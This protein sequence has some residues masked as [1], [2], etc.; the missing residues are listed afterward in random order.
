[1]IAL[2]KRRV[3]NNMMKMSKKALVPALLIGI[4]MI[5][6]VFGAFLSYKAFVEIY[7]K[8]YPLGIV[9]LETWGMKDIEGLEAR[10]DYLGKIRVWT[11]S[12]DAEVV[13]QLMQLSQIVTNFRSF[14]VK[15]CLPLDAVFVVDITGSMIPY[16]EPIKAE[17]KDLVWVLSTMNKCPTQIAVVGFKDFVNETIVN[18]HG[19]TTNYTEVINFIDGLVALDGAGLPQSHYLGLLE[20]ETLFDMAPNSLVHDKIVV[21]ISD[22]QSGYN[23]APEFSYAVQAARGLVDKGVKIHSVL[24][25]VTTPNPTAEAQL[26]WYAE[27]SNG[28]F[29]YAPLPN[30]RLVPGVTSNPTWIVKL[31]PITPFDSFRLKRASSPPTEKKGNYTFGIWV[32][33][34]CKAVPWHEFFVTELTANLEKAEI[35]PYVPEP[36]METPVPPKISVGLIADPIEARITGTIT[37]TWGPILPW[38]PECTLTH[39]QLSLIPPAGATIEFDEDLKLTGSEVWTVVGPAGGWKG[40]VTY[41]YDYMGTTYYAGA[42][43]T[44]TVLP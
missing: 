41:T 24:C 15:V 25:Y 27:V 18:P 30:C 28:N 23:D 37:F 11:Y 32:D 38:P 29:I 9:E 13:L 33:F 19:L 39:V 10:E 7:G 31:T 44:F 6:T 40:Q 3:M 12:N 34:F 20:A 21:F 26:K 16:M 4:M 42:F 43:A 22:A 2:K 1:M 8:K 14:T 17:L 35:P 5:G 36:P